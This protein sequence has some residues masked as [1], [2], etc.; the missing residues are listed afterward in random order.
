MK[1]IFENL[2]NSLSGTFGEALPGVLGAILIIIIGF[3]VAKIVRSIVKKLLGKSRLDE[4][5]GAKL[6]TSF[7][8]DDFIAKLVY[9]LVILYTLII[10]LDLLGVESVLEPLQAMLSQFIG[11]LPNLIGAGVIAFAGYIIGTIGSE[12]TG[13]LSEGLESFGDRIGLST[14]SVNLT[15]VVKQIVFIII[16]IPILIIALDTLNMTAISEPATDMLRSLLLALPKIIA[17]VILLGIF[18]IIGKYVVSIVTTLLQNL[19]MDSLAENMGLGAVLGNRSLSTLIGNV[20]LFFIM[21]T[22]VIAAAGKLE[23]GNVQTILNDVLHISGRVF[24]GL[25][26]LMA[27]LFIS[28]I[29]VNAI[30]KSETNSYMAPIVRF[31]V[32]G[33]FLAFSLHTMGIAESIVNLAFGLTLGAV[34]VAFALSFGLGGREAAGRQM[35]HVFKNIRKEK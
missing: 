8:I 14:G 17:A 22:G 11:F 20:A 9:Y 34:A 16:F 15:S 4:K 1:N 23:L 12:A 35:D 27:G 28:N 31:A 26:I 5:L 19:G 6:N 7:R 3:I 24:F 10:A 33:I 18:F 21:F 25:I 32:M 2:T 13:F 29:A 30:S